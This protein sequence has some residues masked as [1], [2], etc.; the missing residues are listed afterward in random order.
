MVKAACSG[1]QV[2]LRPVFT[3]N[4][5]IALVTALKGRR[6]FLGKLTHDSFDTQ[7]WSRR[8][9]CT[10]EVK[11]FCARSEITYLQ[12]RTGDASCQQ[13]Q[14][15]QQLQQH[16]KSQRGGSRSAGH[17]QEKAP[18]VALRDAEQ[19]TP[20]S[21]ACFTT[22]APHCVSLRAAQGRKG[23]ESGDCPVSRH[24]CTEL[25]F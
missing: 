14:H 12:A 3:S 25:L 24:A 17:L 23:S 9:S 10:R 21:T 4:I 7:T 13:G 18:W 20:R 6:A 16:P 19:R 15:E 8:E 1:S 11:G 22:P 5:A 2:L